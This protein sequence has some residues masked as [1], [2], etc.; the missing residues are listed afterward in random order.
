MAARCLGR[1]TRW[2]ERRTGEGV[3]QNFPSQRGRGGWGLFKDKTDDTFG[4]RA[5]R[6]GQEG[7]PRTH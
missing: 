5:R 2:E 3:F 1:E 7:I 6:E 4:A